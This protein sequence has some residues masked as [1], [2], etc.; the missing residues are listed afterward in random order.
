MAA[1]FRVRTIF[2]HLF[3]SL[4][5]G[6]GI[7]PAADEVDTVF[8]T[9]KGLAFDPFLRKRKHAY[10]RFL[11]ELF[12]ARI[13]E[14]SSDIRCYVGVFFVLRKDGLHRLIFDPRRSNT[15]CEVPP[16]THLPS[17]N[18]IGNMELAAD[19][20]FI[21]MASGDVEC[22]F[23]QYTVPAWCASL[24]GLAPVR[25]QFL[26]KWLRENLGAT[27]DFQEISFRVRVVPMGWNW[28][29]FLITEAQLVMLR[30]AANSAFL[31]D[32]T[33]SLPL[34]TVAKEWACTAIIFLFIDNYGVFSCSAELSESVVTLLTDELDRR[35]VAHTRDPVGHSSFIGFDLDP[36]GTIWRPS[37]AKLRKIHGAGI[38]LAGRGRKFSGKDIEKFVGHATF[39]CGFR[40]ES[41]AVF[42][43]VYKYIAE[44]YDVRRPLWS[45]VAKVIRTFCGIL[46]LLYADMSLPWN[47]TVHA[48]DASL[49]GFG[50]TV[51][52][53]GAELAGRIGR[54][55]EKLDF[56]QTMLLL[57]LLLASLS[58][59][60]ISLAPLWFG[61]QK[62][63]RPKL[64]L[65]PC[66]VRI[67]FPVAGVCTFTS[68]P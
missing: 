62:K 23:Y 25:A 33:P 57:G 40:P 32:K 48:Y 27:R 42:G 17:A 67:S 2:R 58:M 30:A 13:I 65:P 63:Q 59:Q 6:Q 50:I 34:S 24:F 14:V 11:A 18:S 68:F 9:V 5:S 53:L 41:L 31:F 49:D 60:M 37:P 26:P 29:V 54:Q 3:S 10:G 51:A 64:S 12:K 38:W 55:R 66:R 52:D 21:A 7:L 22:C 61:Q 19:S 4:E 46:P 28:S 36:C 44:Q 43:S 8:L 47:G 45:S 16:K 15:L 20:R 35:K 56:R 39:V 1:Q